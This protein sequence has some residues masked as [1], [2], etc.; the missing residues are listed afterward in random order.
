MDQAIIP[1]LEMIEKFTENN[2]LSFHVPGHKN[3]VIL[4]DRAQAHFEHILKL[5]VTELPGLDD[6]HAPHGAILEAEKLASAFFQSDYTFFLINGSTAGNLAMILAATQP[7]DKVIVQRN[8]HKSIM[9]GLELAGARP[10]FLTPEYDNKVQRFTSP[11][12]KTVERSIQE[13]PDAKAVILTYPDYY[14]RTYDI[15]AMID[16]AHQHDI[17]VLVDEA[18]G[19]HFPLGEPFPPSS[20]DL[21]ADIVV[22]SAHKTAPAM[23]MASYIHIRS[24]YIKKE[25]LAYRLQMLQSSSPSYPLMASL[26]MAR[27]FLANQTPESIQTAIE[28]AEKIKSLFAASNLWDIT[29]TNDPIKLT[30]QLK[31]GYAAQEAASLFEEQGIYPELTTERQ[32]LFIFGIYP[33]TE[34]K[35]L[36][37]VLE[38]V[39]ETLKNK[40]NHATIEVVNLFTTKTQELALSYQEMNGLEQ[41]LLPLDEAIGK[42]AAEAVVPYPPGIPLLLKGEKITESHIKAI[43][44]LTREGV[45]IQQRI[46]G[47]RV[48]KQ[49][50]KEKKT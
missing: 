7:G 33:F 18:H 28:D 44:Q 47:I 39:N 46:E 31:E 13:H 3:G 4:P 26:D 20:L 36:R 34:W 45:R 22:H 14:G 30:I 21:G 41:G 38:Y 35:R 5:D 50:L 2:P 8:S 32:I 17:A 10:V 37:K 19:V 48:F 9:N 43:K 29:P 6:L 1:I 15:K 16:F 40:R 49:E 27:Y 24:N 42:I 25:H 12:Y 23:T 11:S